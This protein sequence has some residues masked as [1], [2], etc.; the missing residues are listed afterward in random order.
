MYIDTYMFTFSYPI[1]I[2]R[3]MKSNASLTAS[4][5]EGVISRVLM[6]LSEARAVMRGVTLPSCLKIASVCF[7]ILNSS[8][9]PMRTSMRLGTKK[10]LADI[11]GEAARK[12]LTTWTKVP[13]ESS[14]FSSYS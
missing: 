13:V 1:F 10:S 4:R 2:R 5:W 12:A 14:V 11:C 6:R 9:V 3:I 7:H 8:A